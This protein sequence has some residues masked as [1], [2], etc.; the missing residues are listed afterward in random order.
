VAYASF[1]II[2]NPNLSPFAYF[3]QNYSVVIPSFS[4]AILTGRVALKSGRGE[5]KLFRSLYWV[6][7]VVIVYS[8]INFTGSFSSQSGADD[9]RAGGIFNQANNYGYFLTLFAIISFFDLTNLIRV[10]RRKLVTIIGLVVCLIAILRTGSYGALIFTA[11]IGLFLSYRY[12]IRLSTI[13]LISTIV[14]LIAVTGAIVGFSQSIRNERVEA[15]RSFFSGESNEEVQNQST[16][17]VRWALILKGLESSAESPIVGNGF[18]AR[19]VSMEGTMIP[20]H[21]VFIVEFLK[22]GLFGL[23][24]ILM[25][26]YQIWKSSSRIVN[27]SRSRMA[28][29]L[30]F[31]LFFIDNTLTYSSILSMN[32]GV[33]AVALIT[34]LILY[35]ALEYSKS[36]LVVQN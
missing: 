22:G 32:S 8:E 24:I 10:N 34:S 5:N 19:D 28:L 4:L 30:L 12:L 1:Q 23:A 21:N 15:L 31:Y 6:M 9:F 36:R 3:R 33:I 13:K 7:A 27:K 16:F 2:L 25:L 29:V 35:D 11:A 14:L 20:V 17:D 18:K 26:Y